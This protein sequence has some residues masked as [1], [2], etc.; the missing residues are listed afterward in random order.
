MKSP[1]L[2]LATACT[3]LTLLSTSALSGASVSHTT[4][5]SA[6]TKTV[7]VTR[8]FLVNG[9]E[10]VVDQRTV[11][12]SVSSTTNLRGRQELQVNWSGAHPTGGI[13]ADQNSNL[14]DQEEYLS[15]IHI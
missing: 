11:T 10:T 2:V 4:T 9:N 3:V 14:A 1:R 15:L 7:S 12:V 6:V 5:S 8:S 13:V